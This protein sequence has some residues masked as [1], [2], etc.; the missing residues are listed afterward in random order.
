MTDMVY[1]CDGCRTTL[2]R[3]GC[4]LHRDSNTYAAG[5]VTVMSLVFHRHRWLYDGTDGPY[6]VYHCDDHDPPVV[7]RIWQTDAEAE[8]AL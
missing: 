3:Q 1:G 4:S 7:R 5:G 6:Y 2:G 8:D